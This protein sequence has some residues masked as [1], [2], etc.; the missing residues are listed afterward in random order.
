MED[1]S[2]KIVYLYHSG[3][4]VETQNHF[5]VFD[6]FNDTP[7]NSAR[8]LSNGVVSPSDFPVDKQI[9]VFVTHQ[10]RD[11]FNPII[12]NWDKN[13]SNIKYI[14]SSDIELGEYKNNYFQLDKYETL[15][16]NNVEIST[17]GSTDLGVS[18]LAS[19]DGVTIFHGGDLNWW[20]WKEFSREQQLKEELD[21]KAEVN[22]LIGKKIDIA[23][24]PV[25]PRLEEHYYLA[26]E[27]FINVIKPKLLIPIHFADNCNITKVF[28]EKI[29]D[30]SKVAII[31]KRGQII[32]YTI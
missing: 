22:K 1:K 12:F 2:I 14:L 18:Y 5:L 21:F 8:S 15:K 17:F 9:L 4:A 27:Y 20:H 7:N 10:H 30:N 23:F 13:H 24:I 32:E 25:D 31:E 16:I 26:G 28:A 19:V 11:H 6:Y 29:N 3:F